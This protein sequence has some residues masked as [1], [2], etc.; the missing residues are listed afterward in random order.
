[1]FGDDSASVRVA[2][3]E[4]YV[5]KGGST[6]RDRL[7]LLAQVMSDSTRQLL[8]KA[9]IEPGMHC[10]DVGCGGGEVSIEL[11]R[12]CGPAGSVIG[13]DMDAEQLRIV[14]EEVTKLNLPHLS[15]ACHDVFDWEPQQ[16][17]D[18]I[19][20]RSVLSHLRE[21]SAVL[22]RLCQFLR[23]TGLLI[24]E[25]IDFRGHFSEPQ[26]PAVETFVGLYR[27][28]VQNRGAD[29]CIGPRLPALLRQCGLQDVQ[30]CLCH[31]VALQGGIKQLTS[32]TLEC[33]AHTV[34]KDGLKS[35]TELEPVI[36]ELRAFAEDP[37]TIIGGPRLFQT[38]GRKQAYENGFQCPERTWCGT[39]QP[40][41][42][43]APAD[44][45]AGRE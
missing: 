22:V 38:W 19:Y 4:Q 23:P 14:T 7:R 27:Q 32:L 18:V 45:G 1:M 16:Q 33:I 2:P 10:L 3:S 42:A 13:L 39:H 12:R 5:I 11:A 25:D 28:V 9:G 30:L 34:V 8:D 31:P 37:H 21:P 43:T 44:S 35:A 26:C 15:F 20:M 40:F 17:F 24:V 41:L 6:G 29:P 36:E